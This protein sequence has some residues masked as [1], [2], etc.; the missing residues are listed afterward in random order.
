MSFLNITKQNI[1]LQNCKHEVEHCSWGQLLLLM[2]MKKPVLSFGNKVKKGGLLR[3]MIL[4]KLK[5]TQFIKKNGNKN[6]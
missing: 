6:M 4:N 1:K 3:Q 5:K 2:K